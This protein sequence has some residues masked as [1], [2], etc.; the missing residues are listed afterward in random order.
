MNYERKMVGRVRLE[1]TTNWLKGQRIATGKPYLIK[2]LPMEANVLSR[3]SVS[4]EDTRHPV[5]MLTVASFVAPTLSELKAGFY[6]SRLELGSQVQALPSA[7]SRL[8]P[9]AG[10]S[11]SGGMN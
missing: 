4:N 11:A 3:Q 6:H 10:A 2:V 7:K 9:D 1:R 5:H 8:S